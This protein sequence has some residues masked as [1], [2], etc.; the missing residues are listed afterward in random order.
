MEKNTDIYQQAL[1]QVN[2]CKQQILNKVVKAIKKYGEPIHIGNMVYYYT[3]FNGKDVPAYC[4]IHEY[5]KG[6]NVFSP[7]YDKNNTCLFGWSDFME[8]CRIFDVIEK[9][10]SFNKK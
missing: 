3:R 4:Y 5:V 1:E 8:C 2:V 9:N 7:I 6:L 10:I